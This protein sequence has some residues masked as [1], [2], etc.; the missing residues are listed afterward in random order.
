MRFLAALAMVFSFAA[1]DPGFD[2]TTNQDD[3]SITQTDVQ[4]TIDTT[5][6]SV[7]DVYLYATVTWKAK[8][9]TEGLTLSSFNDNGTNYSYGVGYFPVGADNNLPQYYNGN[10]DREGEY[11]HIINVNSDSTEYTIVSRMRIDNRKEARAY[12]YL[13]KASGTGA[14]YYSQRFYIDPAD[15]PGFGGEPSISIDYT[16]YYSDDESLFIIVTANFGDANQAY[17]VGVCWNEDVDGGQDPT[18]DDEVLNL[19]DHIYGPDQYDSTIVSFNRND[20]GSYTVQ[21]TMPLMEGRMIR[22]RGYLQLERD[23]DIIYTET[24]RIMTAAKK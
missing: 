6:W 7:E 22:L 21:F 16:N 13:V 17:S 3:S 14:F 5:E 19:M 20:N 1:C 24:E 18:V 2:D 12:L 11:H 4:F 8:I 23:G 15:A 9:V 10:N